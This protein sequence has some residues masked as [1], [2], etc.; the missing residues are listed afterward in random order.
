[1]SNTADPGA[2][3][4]PDDSEALDWNTPIDE[5]LRRVEAFREA[6]MPL[7]SL[8]VAGERLY[9]AE[10]WEGAMR[11]FMWACTLSKNDADDFQRLGVSA[12]LAGNT[13][14]ARF[15]FGRVIELNPAGEDAYAHLIEIATRNRDA[16]EVRE[17]ALQR[18]AA[19]GARQAFYADLVERLL[20][21]GDIDEAYRL[22]CQ[23][24]SMPSASAH[25]FQLHAILALRRGHLAE[26]A[27]SAEHM[28]RMDPADVSG[29]MLG[30]EVA[31][32]RNQP[33]V[34]AQ[35]LQRAVAAGVTDA[36]VYR[37]LS[38]ALS[39]MGQL[40][41]AARFAVLATRAAPANSEFWYHLSHV[42]EALGHRDSAFHFLR[43]ALDIDP[44]NPH[45]AVALAAALARGGSIDEAVEV[46]DEAGAGAAPD[47]QVR[48]YRLALLEQRQIEGSAGTGEAR[49][50]P[51]PRS[52]DRL[53]WGDVHSLSAWRRLLVSLQIQGRVISALSVR[54]VAHLSL[55]SR[56]GLATVILEP[57]LHVAATGLVLTYFN[58]GQPPL[59]SNLFFYYATG[60]IPFLMFSH[61][62]DHSLAQ[63]VE[64]RSLLAV[65]MI[66]RVDF[67]IAAALT[68]LLVDGAA[69]FIIFAA[70]WIFEIGAPEGNGFNALTGMLAV[71]LIAFGFA[72]ISAAIN[73]V[74]V[75]WQKIWYTAQRLLYVGSGIFYLPSQLPDW[76]RD[77]II[78]N[79]VLISIEWVRTGFFPQY[80]PPWIDKPYVL[81]FAAVSIMFGLVLERFT[82]PYLRDH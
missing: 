76:F 12:V 21:L 62:V 25:Q 64:N 16:A 31:F 71:W 24:V 77:I 56:F 44:H 11:A 34:A 3:L 7:Q 68:A 82:R 28:C 30:A 74:T 14:L 47:P 33:Q 22:A 81:I 13:D 54:Q 58:H 72:L 32:Q 43:R 6:P 37:M 9:Q 41:E 35:I 78:W 19:L 53:N 48:D 61:I 20:M 51:L 46:L 18:M 63:Y 60:I 40:Q 4:Q 1:M 17:V 10:V 75:V 59:G 80:D 79:P 69:S 50:L 29:A 26:A 70:F 27:Q 42:S 52:H 57:L 5:V 65:R 49:I 2:G 15:A 39:M 23:A 45:I 8:R 66:R 38:G 36:A 55:H 67:I 73:S